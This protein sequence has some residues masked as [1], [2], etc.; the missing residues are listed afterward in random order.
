M[1]F[2]NDPFSTSIRCEEF[3]SVS[4]EEMAEVF[5]MLGEERAAEQSF[6]EWSEQLEEQE[7]EKDWLKGYTNSTEG[8]TYNGLDV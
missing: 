8:D 5:K 1:T 6:A 3:N 7:P 2:Y 4:P